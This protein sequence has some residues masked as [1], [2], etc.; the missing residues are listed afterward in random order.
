MPGYFFLRLNDTSFNFALIEIFSK[1]KESLEVLFNFESELIPLPSLDF[2]SYQ[3]FYLKTNLTKDFN[4]NYASE[5]R[6]TVI[7]NIT[8][9]EGYI[10]FNQDSQ[11]DDKKIQFSESFIFTFTISEKIKT[12]HLFSKKNLFFYVKIKNKKLNDIMEELNFGSNYKNITKESSYSKAYYIKDIYGNGI[13]ANFFFDKENNEFFYEE[14]SI[15]GY[16]VNYDDIKYIDS[17]MSLEQKLDNYLNYNIE[18]IN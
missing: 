18:Q 15:Q 1:N 11:D 7:I 2:Y 9:G 17:Y 8:S 5:N 12:V 10:Y 14:I 16:I 3:S 6:N 13:D 4:F